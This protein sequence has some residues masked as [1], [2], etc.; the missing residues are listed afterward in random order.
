MASKRSGE[1]PTSKQSKKPPARD[2]P[3][4]FT[5]TVLEGA[6][7]G[8]SFNVDASSPPRVLVGQSP[9]CTIVLHDR[10]VSRRHLAMRPTPDVLEIRDLESTN[11]STVNGVTIREA[12]LRGGEVLRLGGTVISVSR[13]DPESAALT[14]ASSFGRLLGE[15]RAMRKIYPVLEQ[16][17]AWEGPVLIEG[18]AGTGKELCA[19]ELHARSG[20]KDGPFLTLETATLD[21]DEI[22][23]R[24]FGDGGLLRQAEGGTLVIDDASDLPLAVQENLGRALDEPRAP[25]VVLTTVH[26]LD[27]AAAEGRFRED[28]LARV[29]SSHVTLPPLRDRDADVTLLARAFWTAIG[30]PGSELPADF[31][32]RFAH[33]PWTGNVRELRT[34][35]ETRLHLGEF[36]TWGFEH[37]VR[38][39]GDFIGAVLAKRLPFVQAKRVVMGEFERRYVEEL[40]AEHG[41]VQRAAHASGLA[42]RY[43]LLIRARHRGRSTS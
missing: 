1:L 7:A 37:G 25:K 13:G 40:I 19:E 41:S 2:T 16:L 6:D 8:A 20:R 4:T 17:A 3:S 39:E 33:H 12:V 21:A 24:L 5:L 30:P 28:L 9:L 29:A 38:P 27:R 15:S 42:Q 43:F 34:A 22:D 10:E 36:A 26:D 32:P 31:T 35:I 23:A 11:G 18:E 14:R